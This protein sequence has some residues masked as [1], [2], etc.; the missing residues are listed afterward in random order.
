MDNSKFSLHCIFSLVLLTRILGNGVLAEVITLT[1]WCMWEK[2]DESFAR[3]FALPYHWI[4]TT[5]KEVAAFMIVNVNL[6]NPRAFY[7]SDIFQFEK[8]IERES[9]VVEGKK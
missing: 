8:R 5:I 2:F 9:V 3:S 1:F 6:D 4:T 7:R